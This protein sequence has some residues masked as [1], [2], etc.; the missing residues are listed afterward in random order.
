MYTID[1]QRSHVLSRYKK[2]I[3]LWTGLRREIEDYEKVE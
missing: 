1:R 2:N 3:E